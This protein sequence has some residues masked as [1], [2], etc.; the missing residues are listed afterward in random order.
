MDIQNEIE[1]EGKMLV[2]LTD[3]VDEAKDGDYVMISRAIRK[4]VVDM[5]NG[6]CYVLSGNGD[7][8]IH[9]SLVAEY[10]EAA[11]REKK[12]VVYEWLEKY[13]TDFTLHVEQ[14]NEELSDKYGSPEA[15]MRKGAERSI[16]LSEENWKAVEVHMMRCKLFDDYENDVMFSLCSQAL[17]N[18]RPKNK[19]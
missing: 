10:I 14:V 5:Q 8:K 2:K 9:L 16:Q 7:S 12:P 4:V 15:L 18:C 13:R 17:A 3:D 19:E 11:Y 6:E 1:H